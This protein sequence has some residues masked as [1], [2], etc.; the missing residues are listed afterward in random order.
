M[1]VYCDVSYS[2]K[3]IAKAKGAK[4]DNLFKCWYFIDSINE[5]DE[6]LN[7]YKIKKFQEC[8]ICYE[9]KFM[10]KIHDNHLCCKECLIK[11]S[12]CPLCRQQKQKK[13]EEENDTIE[14]IYLYVPFEYKEDAKKDKL[15]WDPD[16]KQWY[17]IYN[18]PNCQKL[19]EK[20]NS[21]CFYS[22]F[23]GY[24]RKYNSIN[25]I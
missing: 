2:D 10:E 12:K 19:K 22:N 8:L 21:K 24:H 6:Y 3:D 9:N 13:K 18:N 1:K 11:I 25:D 15:K 20:W 23:H 17:T 4:W 7:G 14:K 16:K 5:S